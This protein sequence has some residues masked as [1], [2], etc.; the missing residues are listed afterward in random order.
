MDNICMVIED[1]LLQSIGASLEMELVN[2]IQS[3]DDV[4]FFKVVP[5]KRLS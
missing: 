1:K 3:Q 2:T 5:W 4:S